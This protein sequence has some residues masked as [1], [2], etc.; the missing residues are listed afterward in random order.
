MC[1][2]NIPGFVRD[3][4][5]V[6]SGDS[7]E[8]DVV[9]AVIGGGSP[10]PHSDCGCGGHEGACSCET[11]VVASAAGADLEARV[12]MLEASNAVLVDA[13]GADVRKRLKDRLR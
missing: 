13:L 2:V 1:S 4:A 10:R 3:L 12:A 5:F 9:A 6:A 11:P 7:N 8:M